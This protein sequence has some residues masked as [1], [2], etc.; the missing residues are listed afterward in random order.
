MVVK[1]PKCNKL[2]EVPKE[3]LGKKEVCEHC[4]NVFVVDELVIYKEPQ[5]PSVTTASVSSAIPKS[6]TSI[7]PSI[8]QVTKKKP[9]V[10]LRILLTAIITIVVI[11]VIGIIVESRQRGSS[12][13]TSTP[14]TITVASGVYKIEAGSYLYWKFNCSQGDKLTGYVSVPEYDINVWLIKGEREFEAFRRGET[15]YYLPSAS[16]QKTSYH[17]I[18]CRLESDTYYIIL[19]NRYSM[20]RSK[21]P[22]IQLQLE[23]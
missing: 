4:D 7:P 20:F 12:I 19:D 14:T 13:Y 15:F 2:L 23:K 6:A 21:S 1:C 11:V 22:M 5:P 9:N 16:A 17:S 8:P 18:D 10:V 3:K